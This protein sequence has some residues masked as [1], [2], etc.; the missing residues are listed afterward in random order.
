M[1]CMNM[2][3]GSEVVDDDNAACLRIRKWSMT[4]LLRRE[5]ILG[6]YMVFILCQVPTYLPYLVFEQL[7]RFRKNFDPIASFRSLTHSLV[8]S[9]SSFD[10]L[11]E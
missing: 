1:R 9:Y 5:Y 11:P 2:G 10:A 3:A 6:F 8:S 7:G 4:R